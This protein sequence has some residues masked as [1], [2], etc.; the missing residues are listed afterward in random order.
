IF[1]ARRSFPRLATA[2]LAFRN[3]GDLTF[4]EMGHAWGF[5]TAG[6][7]NGM[8]LADLDNDGDLDVVMNNL[9]GVPGIYR[10]ESDA[11]RV[12]VRLKGLSP[13]THGIGAKIRVLGGAVPLQ[14]QEMIAGGR[15]LSSDDTVRAFAA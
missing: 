12:A 1:Q 2:N 4:E 11:P 7:S 6:I 13:N 10:N 14:S 9:N 3:R 5:D 15:Y 8:A